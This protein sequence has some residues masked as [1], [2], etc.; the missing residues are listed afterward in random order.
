MNLQKS[1]R[2]GE[3]IVNSLAVMTD[4]E[5]K[6]IQILRHANDLFEKK[7]SSELPGCI[8][9]LFSNQFSRFLISD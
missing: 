7:D 2:A 6:C 8:K 3:V 9:D 1:K 4:F 5:R